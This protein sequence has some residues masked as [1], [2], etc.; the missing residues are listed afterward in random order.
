MN[1]WD[2]RE[3][4]VMPDPE[5]SL[6]IWHPPVKNMSN[7]YMYARKEITLQQAHDK[8]STSCFCGCNSS[9]HLFINGIFIGRGAASSDPRWPYLDEY[10][11]GP[12]LHRGVNVIA[13]VCYNYGQ[14][15]PS[16]IRQNRGPG[17]FYF[18]ADVYDGDGA[19]KAVVISDTS[20]RVLH[21]ESWR[22]DMPIISVHRG[23]YKTEYL[24]EREPD[25]WMLPGYDDSQWEEAVVSSLTPER[26]LLRPFKE[27]EG[28]E[29]PVRVF[30][31]ENGTTFGF[32]DKAVRFVTDPMALIPD[33]NLDAAAEILVGGESGKPERE[34]DLEPRLDSGAATA[35]SLGRKRT[36][37]REV[38]IESDHDD[39]P[40]AIIID[41][42]SIVTGYLDVDI[43][44]SAGGLV[45][46]AYGESLN[47]T[48][49]D[50]IVLKPGGAV[51]FSPWERRTAR[52]VLLSFRNLRGPVRLESVKFRT[53]SYPVAAAGDFACSDETLNRIWTVGRNTLQTCMHEYY[54]DCP[55]REQALYAADLH[56]EALI[57][58]YTFGDLV[59]ARESIR[60]LARIQFDDG[61]IP[62]CGPAAGFPHFL[63][64][65]VPHWVAALK[66]YVLFSADK[67]LVDELYP[68]LLG[69]YSW[70]EKHLDE[71][72]LLPLSAEGGWWCFLD[73]GGIEK[74][75]QVT[76]LLSLYHQMLKDMTWLAE[77][78]SRTDDARVFSSSASKLRTAINS[79]L[80][81]EALGAY[82]DSRDA[83]LLLGNA[84]RQTN[85]LAVICGL[86]DLDD[87][88]K[89]SITRFFAG[90]DPEDVK[91]AFLNFY[92]AMALFELGAV[93]DALTLVRR[94]W[95]EMLAR[96]ATSFWETFDPKTPAG[97][98]PD[99]MWSLCHGFSAGP[100]ALLSG[101]V[102]GIRPVS[103]GF[104]EFEIE[105]QGLTAGI[106]WARARVPTPSGDITVKW[107]VETRGSDDGERRLVVQVVKPKGLRAV[108]VQVADRVECSDPAF[109]RVQSLGQR[110]RYEYRVEVDAAAESAEV[111]FIQ[112]GLLGG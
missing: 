23:G 74:R 6:W 94:Y 22:Q 17:G 75:G 112:N 104:A 105:P 51:H 102:A 28:M 65:F 52:M 55:W 67:T 110:H 29:Y 44:D 26:R 91:T 70:F 14:D 63:P 25:G 18:H 50:R 16:G 90:T 20:W 103:P 57:N 39:L 3:S 46:I 109:V 53:V 62:S 19:D 85:A 100:N 33:M 77:N 13:A 30:T 59:L 78:T 24:A 73:W 107:H 95:G 49:V 32:G 72:G 79:L 58:Y 15:M 10:D 83:G 8:L 88:K 27:S 42:G 9:Y 7:F 101:K 92:V 71:D 98:W 89:E 80:W 86:I 48:Y 47:M 99:R 108:V 96:G 4:M 37:H 45:D 64:D 111:E 93:E 5:Q 31:L 12:L 61:R 81:D 38:V 82:A 76:G 69:L 43:S 84:T 106:E 2:P 36:A 41:F 56:M 60:Q 11:I 68:N 97:A 34:R 1:R 87:A 54:E 40:P 21:T 35:A 66:D